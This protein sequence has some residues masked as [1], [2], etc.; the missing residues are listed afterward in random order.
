[1]APNS[2]GTECVFSLLKILF[3]SNQDTNL[4]G[5]I[6]GSIILRYS[7]TKRANAAR[8]PLY[9]VYTAHFAQKWSKNGT[10]L[11]KKRNEKW[12]F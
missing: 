9:M 8:N 3:G 4:S 5:Y 12:R 2:A 1:M 11:A 7:N 10:Y 6:R